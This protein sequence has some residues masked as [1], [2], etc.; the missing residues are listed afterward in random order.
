MTIACKISWSPSSTLGLTNHTKG[1]KGTPVWTIA[2]LEPQSTL[3]KKRPAV[4]TGVGQ[5]SRRPAGPFR[6]PCLPGKFGPND[7]RV[8]VKPRLGYVPKELSTPFRAHV[9]VLSALSPPTGSKQPLLCPVRALKVYI[10]RSASY[11]K[12]EQLFVDFGNRAQGGL[13]TKQR[14][15]RWLMDAITLA[16]SS[17]GL[18]AAGFSSP[19]TLV[20]IYNLDVP[21]LQARVL[22]ALVAIF[23]VHLTNIVQTPL[24]LGLS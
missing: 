18:Q 3:V 10:E 1:P 21:A 12:S 8:V 11:R 19:S 14:I 7:S 22:S 23:R 2:I 17:L 16:Y 15:S 13:V 5:A 9:I 20:R 6:Q 24:L 4:S